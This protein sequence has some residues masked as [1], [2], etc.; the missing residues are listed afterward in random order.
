MKT[1]RLL[2][3]AL[4]A[5]LVMAGFTACSSDDDEEGKTVIA[6][7]VTSVTSGEAID[8][9]LPSGTKWASRNV[10]AN[11]PED[12][13]NFFAWGDTEGSDGYGEFYYEFNDCA[14]YGLKYEEMLSLGIIDS[15]GDLT[16]AYDAATAN[17][18][19]SWRMPTRSEME[20]LINNCTV[21]WR[22]LNG[23]NGLYVTSSNGNSIFLPSAGELIQ[24]RH[25]VGFGSYWS[26]TMGR[27]SYSTEARGLS[28]GWDGASLY[29]NISVT[30]RG[31][32]MSVRPVLKLTK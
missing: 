16:S 22:S 29:S 5:T 12:Y 15:D 27:T 31:Y 26:S 30:D 20:E 6:T 7:A 17:L 10:G 2:G 25:P 32:G 24:S 23:V 4:V 19:D 21:A 9:G 13:G 11:S 14:T 1:L 3:V 8:L 28:F 18:G